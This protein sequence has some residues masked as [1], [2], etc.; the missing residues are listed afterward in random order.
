[1]NVT[2]TCSDGTILG[3]YEVKNGKLRPVSVMLA[4]G[5]TPKAGTTTFASTH[6]VDGTDSDPRS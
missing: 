1:M 6:D 4:A 2:L 3:E 5:M